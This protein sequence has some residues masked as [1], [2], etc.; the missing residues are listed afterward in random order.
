MNISTIMAYNRIAQM[1]QIMNNLMMQAT[2]L[3]SQINSTIIL[4]NNNSFI[5]MGIGT[6]IDI[7]A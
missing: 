4:R 6:R 7:F 2:V 3:K 1:N 5:D